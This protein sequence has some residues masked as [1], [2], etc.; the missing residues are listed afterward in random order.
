M[1]IRNRFDFG[2][3]LLEFFLRAP[4]VLMVI[5]IL[6][7]PTSGLP[8][9]PQEIEG[10]EVP[11]SAPFIK[12]MDELFPHKILGERPSEFILSLRFLPAFSPESQIVISKKLQGG[13]TVTVYHL[14]R[15]SK[16]IGDQYNQIQ[17]KAKDDIEPAEIAK[18]IKVLAEN[19]DVPPSLISRQLDRLVQVQVSPLEELD[20]GV[21]HLDGTAYEFFLEPLGGP[22]AFHAYYESERYGNPP[23]EHPLD[24]WMEEMK[25]LVEK[26]TLKDSPAK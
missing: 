23:K 1:K 25:A 18:Q 26:Y 19:V 13:Y 15:G 17:L 21:A 5:A 20:V 6:L 16:N 22:V 10:G 2:F 14:P 24:V 9:P 11:P 7:V 8:A 3:P 4:L 12:T